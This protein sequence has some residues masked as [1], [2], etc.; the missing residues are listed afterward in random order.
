ILRELGWG[1][2]ATE[3]SIQEESRVLVKALSDL[4]G[5][6]VLIRKFIMSSISAHITTLLFGVRYTHDHPVRIFLNNSFK[7]AGQ[8]LSLRTLVLF[9]PTWLYRI[10]GLIP[11]SR[12]YTVKAA[13]RGVV[14]FIKKQVN[15]H[16]E[17]QNDHSSRDYID[18]FLKETKERRNDLKS[19]I[20]GKYRNS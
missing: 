12:Y 1:T 20:R 9:V 7:T 13:F 10:L 14:K 3:A 2:A 11:F 16:M 17:T 8:I 19:Y 4:N 6:P 5:K 15:D 18:A